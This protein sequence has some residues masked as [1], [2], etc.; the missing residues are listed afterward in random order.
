MY[1][2]TLREKTFIK[3]MLKENEYKPIKY[4]S[5][6]LKVSDKTLKNDLS[7]I[8]KYLDKYP[9]TLDKKTGYGIIIKIDA[10][11]KRQLLND[12]NSLREIQ[13]QLSIVSRRTEIIKLLLIES[14]TNTSIQKLSDK[15]Y[16]SKASI[17]ND[18]K[19]I[20]EWL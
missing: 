15:Y 4:F 3:L 14:N 6:M 13:D 12:I 20:E 8:E 2:L 9:I 11:T 1:N 16:V 19:Y 17:V 5:N 10:N 7:V 18:F